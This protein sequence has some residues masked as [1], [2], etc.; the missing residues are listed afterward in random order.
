[1]IKGFKRIS[2]L[3]LLAS[4][5]GSFSVLPAAIT[6]ISLNDKWNVVLTKVPQ[7]KKQLQDVQLTTTLPSTIHLDLL[8]HNK[9]EDPFHRDNYPKLKW[10]SQCNA[11]YSKHFEV[12]QTNLKRAA[13]LVF[14]GIDTYATVK[15]NGQPI[16]KANNAFVRYSARVEKYLQKNNL[17]EVDIMSS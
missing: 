6:Q 10:V 1:M 9:I 7:S 16:I 8:K 14:H 3:L 2:L 13:E 5:S 12:D 17:L 11:R 4:L 15:L